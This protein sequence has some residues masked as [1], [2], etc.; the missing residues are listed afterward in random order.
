MSDSEKILAKIEIEDMELYFTDKR[1]IFISTQRTQSPKYVP[2]VGGLVGGALG[3]VV[4]E[5]IFRSRQNKRCE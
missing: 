3:G 4:A 1:F 5:I 2:V